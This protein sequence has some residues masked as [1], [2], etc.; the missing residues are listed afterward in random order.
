MSERLGARAAI[1]RFGTDPVSLLRDA[2]VDDRPVG[3]LTWTVLAV[4]GWFF[5]VELAVALRYGVDTAA[6][7][8]YFFVEHPWVVWPLAPFLHRGV[9]HVA[10]NLAAV[11]VAAP[12]ERRLGASRYVA[13]LFAAGYLPVYAEG[14]KLAVYGNSPNVAAY[15]ISGFAFGLLG[16]G[17]VTHV[18]STWRLTPRWWLV[19]LGGVSAVLAV[20]QDALLAVG[21][22]VSLHL[23]HLGGLLVGAGFAA[24]ERRA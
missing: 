15:G 2:L 20:L 6:V 5:A 14:V 12:V 3:R 23:G 16:Y 8:S 13:L 19:V 7:V 18:G 21:D 10:L 24:L 22:P 11:Y 1:E 4:A 9:G 17:L